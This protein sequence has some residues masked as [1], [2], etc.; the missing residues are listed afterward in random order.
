MFNVKTGV[1]FWTDNHLWTEK[2][3]RKLSEDGHI[4]WP[5]WM[6]H[7]GQ[8]TAIVRKI[9]TRWRTEPKD[10]A[11]ICNFGNILFFRPKSTSTKLYFKTCLCIFPWYKYWNIH[12]WNFSWNSFVNLCSPP[13]HALYVYIRIC[14]AI[15]HAA[16]HIYT[17]INI[18]DHLLFAVYSLSTPS[19]LN[20]KPINRLQWN[21]ILQNQ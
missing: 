17:Y 15:T 9:S 13:K 16:F 4:A 21:K 19:T 12:V 3:R 8:I 14:K 6:F 11:P 5:W 2:G 20:F 7:H 10:S 18:I 1:S